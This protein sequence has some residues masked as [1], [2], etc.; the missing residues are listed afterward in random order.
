[1]VNVPAVPGSVKRNNRPSQRKK[2][3]KKR[4]VVRNQN[5][6]IPKRIVRPIDPKP[7]PIGLQPLGE[8]G[9]SVSKNVPALG[10]VLVDDLSEAGRIMLERRTGLGD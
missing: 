1:M 2:L 6:S 8:P 9:M 7:L 5:A 4:R 10:P 3:G